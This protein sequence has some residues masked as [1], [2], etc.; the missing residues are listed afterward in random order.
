MG[1]VSGSGA[2]GDS[3]GTNASIRETDLGLTLAWGDTGRGV[4][5]PPSRARGIKSRVDSDT[6]TLSHFT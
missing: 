5:R 1:L 6:R 2:R 3:G 4:D